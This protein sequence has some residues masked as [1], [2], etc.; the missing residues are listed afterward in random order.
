MELECVPVGRVLVDAVL[1]VLAEG[2]VKLVEVLLLLGDLVEELDALLDEV[3]A[4]D[5]EDLALL[6]HLARDIEREVLAVHH[7][8]DEV[9]VLGHELLAVLH[10][11][12]AA[13]VELDGVLL[14]AVLEQVE[15]R[16]LRNEQQLEHIVF[17]AL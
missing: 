6:E 13:H 9:E 11:E 2:L 8:A 4:D 16:A 7:A 17:S 5:L 12:H 1:E 3:L 10:D 15:G 14:L